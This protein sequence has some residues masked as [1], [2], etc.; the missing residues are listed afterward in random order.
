MTIPGVEGSGE[1]SVEGPDE[2]S[3]EGSGFLVAGAASFL[4]TPNK[5]S[6]LINQHTGCIYD[7][8]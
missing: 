8:F 7:F 5:T 6:I 1:G 4:P 2:G 3:G